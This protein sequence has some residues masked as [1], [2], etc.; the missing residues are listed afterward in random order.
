[1][2]IVLAQPPSKNGF[3]GGAA[4]VLA[5]AYMRMVRVAVGDKGAVYRV[6]DINKKFPAAQY[7][8]LL[9]RVMTSAGGRW[10]KQKQRAWA[11][12]AAAGV[13]VRICLVEVK[14]YLIFQLGKC[15]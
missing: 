1:M 6:L 5:H 3:A 11:N 12:S 13:G 15:L 10:Q 9:L 14:S 2:D 4:V 7:R 8:P